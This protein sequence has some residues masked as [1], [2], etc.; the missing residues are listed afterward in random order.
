[1]K[2]I[3]AFVFSLVL[4]CAFAGCDNDNKDKKAVSASK[5]KMELIVDNQ[6]ITLS[7][8]ITY[9]DLEDLGFTVTKDYKNTLED[10]LAPSKENDKVTASYNLK[11]SDNKVLAV[12][13]I[14]LN[15]KKVK[16]KD[17]TL[18]FVAIYIDDSYTQ[19]YKLPNNVKSGYS[20]EKIKN[21]M[22]TPTDDFTS[23]P[24]DK[25]L[26]YN[27]E[28]V[29]EYVLNLDDDLTLQGFSITLSDDFLF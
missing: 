20:D 1:M 7:D 9:S 15:S 3:L 22:G 21:A 17:A 5:D 12:S 24:S 23:L 2:K 14:N 13:V 18:Y 19:N 6:L 26:K 28:N 27:V 10:T 25:M 16:V 29:G 4:I 8:K 11:C